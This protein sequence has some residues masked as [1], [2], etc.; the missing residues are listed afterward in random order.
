[1]AL[2]YEGRLDFRAFDVLADA[3]ENASPAMLRDAAKD[4]KS[5]AND[6]RFGGVKRDIFREFARILRK[7]AK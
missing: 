6:S 5:I 3:I 4:C 7:Q 1:M 2:D